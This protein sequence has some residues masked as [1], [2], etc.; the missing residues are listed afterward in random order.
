MGEFSR[1]VGEKGE[2]LV[3]EL[4]SIMGWYHFQKDESISCHHTKKHKRSGAKKERT[5]HGIDIFFSSRSQLQDFT[6]ENV[7]LS[8]KYTNSAYPANPTSKFKEHFRDLAETVECFMKS[9]LRTQNNEDYE[10]SGINGAN[11][12]GVLFWLSNHKDSEQDIVSK[13][14]NINLDK[15]LNFSTIH[16]VDNSRAAFI[17][18]SISYIRNNF[19]EYDY[20]FHYA[21]SSSNYKDPDIDKY[22]SILPV[23]YLT[24]NI[25]PFRLIDKSNQKVSFCL[26]SRDEFSEETIN[27]LLYLVSDVSLDFTG[28]F[29]FL[30]P[31]YDVIKHEHILKRAKRLKNDKRKSLNITVKSY[32]NDFRNLINE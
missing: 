8:V 10:M 9:D 25:I 6:L 4:L 23:E 20:Y 2:K 21:F 15:T 31:D 29:V 30:F 22:G 24:S 7:I 19:N 28:D 12:T 11:D 18:N 16:V 5:T 32:N 27:R 3:C 1:K 26:A 14:A 13:V 17:Y